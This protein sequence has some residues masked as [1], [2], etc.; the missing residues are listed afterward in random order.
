MKSGRHGRRQHR[1][2]RQS[3]APPGLLNLTSMI[4]IFTVLL[5]FLLVYAA[6]L[7]IFT[8]MSTLNLSLPAANAAPAP[9]AP[10]QL[11][12]MIRQSELELLNNGA[13]RLRL[14][15][16]TNG[17]NDGAEFATLAQTLQALKA[18]SPATRQITISPEPEVPYETL[19]HVMDAVRQGDGKSGGQELF[20]DIL[21]GTAPA[22]SR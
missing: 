17:R 4:D 6:E 9:A 22:A 21:M 12:V 10:L 15:L 3:L 18:Q 11:E 19:V 2:H 14:S 20:P 1:R 8:P 5:F 13:S 7:A 16:S